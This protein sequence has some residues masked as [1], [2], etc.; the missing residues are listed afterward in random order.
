VGKRYSRLDEIGIP[1]GITIDFDTIDD[2]QV[3]LREI[4]SMDQIRLPL[5]QVVQTVKACV[6]G[7]TCWKDLVAK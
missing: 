5:E 2:K 3:T 1:F 6:D 7:F 4:N